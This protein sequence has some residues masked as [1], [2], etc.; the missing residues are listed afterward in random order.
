MVASKKKAQGARAA[1]GPEQTMKSILNAS[2]AEFA[3]HGFAGTRIDAIA[4]RAKVNKQ[5][6]YYHFGSK[7]K[8]YS[9]VLEDGYGLVYTS[10]REGIS[11]ASL[12]EAAPLRAIKILVESF[13]DSVVNFPEVLDIVTDENKYKGAHLKPKGNIAKI[14]SPYIE[15]FRIAIEN[16]QKNGLFR[17]NL[18]P[19]EAWIST[20]AVCR[21]WWNHRYTLSHNLAKDITTPELVSERRK[22]VV[23]FV[24]SA[25]KD[26]DCKDHP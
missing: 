11:N 5:A 23:E 22:H 13:F 2:R 19:Y 18:D 15:Q 9:A 21:F 6:L 10:M 7:D 1:G 20:I 12:E 26:S 4:R 8:L 25:L 16:G 14:T 3:K 17:K 24:L